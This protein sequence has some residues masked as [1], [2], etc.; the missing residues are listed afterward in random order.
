MQ[1]TIYVFRSSLSDAWQVPLRC[2]IFLGQVL[3]VSVYSSVFRPGLT[4]CV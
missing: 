1:F 4:L 3:F 2:F